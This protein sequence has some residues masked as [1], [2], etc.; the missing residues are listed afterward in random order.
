MR[1]EAN[2]VRPMP[3]FALQ[4]DGALFISR[5]VYQFELKSYILAAFASSLYG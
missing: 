1:R 3:G 2:R 5:R 4:N